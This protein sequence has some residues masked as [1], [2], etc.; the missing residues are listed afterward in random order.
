MNFINFWK[1]LF[2]NPKEFFMKNIGNDNQQPAYFTLAIIVFGIGHGID[3]L[4]IQLTKY[5]LKGKLDDVEFINNWIGYWLFAVIGGIIGGYILYLIGGWFFNVR[6][7]WSKGSSD[8]NKSRYIYLYS[9]V[10]SSAVIILITIIS[11][12][13]NNKPYDPESEF[14]LWELTSLILL[15]IFLYY[16]V[17]V[18]YSGVRTITDAEKLGVKFGS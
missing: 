10:V 5:D 2:I 8:I 15:L 14:N 6:L 9:G 11:M 18:S 13:L 1:D 7:K 17:Y 4:D 3:R 12:F 16:S